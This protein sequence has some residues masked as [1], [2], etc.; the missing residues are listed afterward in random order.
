VR[1]GLVAFRLRNVP[2]EHQDVGQPLVHRHNRRLRRGNNGQVGAE[3][4]ADEG[5]EWSRLRR[6]GLERENEIHIEEW[7]IAV[8]SICRANLPKNAD[9]APSRRNDPG[10]AVTKVKGARV[11]AGA[12][13]LA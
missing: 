11:R 9:N 13:R 10:R 2:A 3:F 7:A 5:C 4:S 12:V 8:Q 1:S 6:V